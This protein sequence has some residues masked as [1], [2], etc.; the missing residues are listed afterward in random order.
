MNDLEICK[1]IAEIEGY[2]W[3][4]SVGANKRIMLINERISTFDPIKNKA[5]CFDLMEEYKV[6]LFNYSDHWEAENNFDS[7]A[8]SSCVEDKNPQRAICLAI[9]KAHEQH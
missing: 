2:K 1:R 4:Y 6:S 7:D 9:I 3:D 5:L 8:C